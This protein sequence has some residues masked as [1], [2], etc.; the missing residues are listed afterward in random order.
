MFISPNPFRFTPP[1]WFLRG[2]DGL[3]SVGELEVESVIPLDQKA[4]FKKIWVTGTPHTPHSQLFTPLQLLPRSCKWHLTNIRYG[5]RSDY[6]CSAARRLKLTAHLLQP[7]RRILASRTD[8]SWWLAEIKEQL[9]KHCLSLFLLFTPISSTAPL[10]SCSVSSHCLHSCAGCCLAFLLV[11]CSKWLIVTIPLS[12]SEQEPF[13]IAGHAVK[14]RARTHARTHKHAR[15]RYF[16]VFRWR[17]AHFVYLPLQ[18]ETSWWNRNLIL[19][20]LIKHLVS[21]TFIL[22]S[23][24]ELNE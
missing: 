21:W 10:F 17:R 3:K 16:D 24:S 8:I 6:V 2:I 20:L 9:F 5:V 18:I 23:L 1:T 11:L 14:M 13:F 4:S 19:P 12:Q 22:F 7:L 15:K